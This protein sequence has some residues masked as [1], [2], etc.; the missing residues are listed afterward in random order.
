MIY[1]VIATSEY[2]NTPVEQTFTFTDLPHAHSS[3]LVSI[4]RALDEQ[5][6]R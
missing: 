2:D 4:M 1:T 3:H 5:A 6:L